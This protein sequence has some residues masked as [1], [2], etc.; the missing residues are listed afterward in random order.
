MDECTDIRYESLGIA[1][2]TINEA[3]NAL[4][5]EIEG[6]RIA[7]LKLLLEPARHLMAAATTKRVYHLMRYARKERARRK[8]QNRLFKDYIRLI[9]FIE[10]KNESIRDSV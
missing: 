4:I 10:D 7:I 2:D 6:V 9:K 8:N 1:I 3:F 5:P